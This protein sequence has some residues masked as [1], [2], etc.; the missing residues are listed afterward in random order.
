[1]STRGSAAEADSSDEEYLPEQQRDR[2]TAALAR[3]EEDCATEWSGSRTS[4]PSLRGWW[5]VQQDPAPL[6]VN[7]YCIRLNA[8]SDGVS[9]TSEAEA[10]NDRTKRYTVRLDAVQLCG[11]VVKLTQTIRDGS[12]TLWKGECTVLVDDNASYFSG[13]YISGHSSGVISGARVEPVVSM[14]DTTTQPWP[15]RP[16]KAVET[17]ANNSTAP[18]E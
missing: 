4:V 13:T 3:L 14:S 9:G 10:R 6:E 8:T 15:P 5:L 2:L 18:G 16:P 11:L 17:E 1:M 7:R 12:A